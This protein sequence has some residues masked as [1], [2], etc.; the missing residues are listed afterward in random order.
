[1]SGDHA[2]KSAALFDSS[3]VISYPSI[4]C[5][6]ATSFVFQFLVFVA[7]QLN[8]FFIFIFSFVISYTIYII[9]QRLEVKIAKVKNFK[10]ICVIKG[11]L[12]NKRERKERAV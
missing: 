2:L 8:Y 11:L 9:H 3:L 6:W 5:S 7:A 1:M 4:L 12:M 10:I